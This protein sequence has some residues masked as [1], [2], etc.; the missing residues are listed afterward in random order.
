M[1]TASTL[2]RERGPCCVELKT[3]GEEAI[4]SEKL[5]LADASASLYSTARQRRRLLH[6]CEHS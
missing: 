3:V 4:R 5:K 2:G 6:A 1:F